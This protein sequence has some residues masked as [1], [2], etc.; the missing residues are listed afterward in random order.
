MNR[1]DDISTMRECLQV[2]AMVYLVTEEDVDQRNATKYWYEE[3]DK[4]LR[5]REQ[6][7]VWPSSDSLRNSAR[8]D[9]WLPQL[10]SNTPW[11]IHPILS[12]IW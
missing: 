4:L 7:P 10:K 9:R 11:G 1:N 8:W 6:P 3:I 5:E 12:W 2:T